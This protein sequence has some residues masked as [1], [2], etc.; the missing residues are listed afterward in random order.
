MSL[1][2]HN[3]DPHYH[4]PFEQ[5]SVLVPHRRAST[6]KHGPAEQSSPLCRSALP[7]CCAASRQKKR[8]QLVHKVVKAGGSR[9]HAHA[10]LPWLP[11]TST[12]RRQASFSSILLAGMGLSDVGFRLRDK[13]DAS[14]DT[15][16][17]LRS[18]AVTVLRWRLLCLG[19][20]LR[21]LPGRALPLQARSLWSALWTQMVVLNYPPKRA[22]E[23]QLKE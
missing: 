20:F 7:G 14:G 16:A 12:P 15:R 21:C 6:T 23:G 9:A 8:T 13:K 2:S 5:G 10:R 18:S 1:L 19:S 11:Q 17:G 3:G 22:M 4:G